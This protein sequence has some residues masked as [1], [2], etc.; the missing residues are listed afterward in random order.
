MTQSLAFRR[1]ITLTNTENHQAF[2]FA[3]LDTEINDPNPIAGLTKMLLVY[4]CQFQSNARI[5]VPQKQPLKNHINCH[6]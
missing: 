6:Y 3:Q 5:F 1:Q 4:A 2:F